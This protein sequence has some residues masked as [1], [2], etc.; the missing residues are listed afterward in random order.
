[1]PVM[2]VFNCC[3]TFTHPL[4]GTVLVLYASYIYIGCFR[5]NLPY[6]GRM[7]VM[8]IYSSITKLICI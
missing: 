8:V 6:L 4:L 1:M 3:S 5:R 7:C 2:I